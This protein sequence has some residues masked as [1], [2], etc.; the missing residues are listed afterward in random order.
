[1]NSKWRQRRFANSGTKN[2]WFKVPVASRGKQTSKRKSVETKS[3]ETKSVK[4]KCVKKKSSNKK[5][6][7]EC[8]PGSLLKAFRYMGLQRNTTKFTTVLKRNLRFR[9]VV[10]CVTGFTKKPLTAKTF[11][12][13]TDTEPNILYLIQITSTFTGDVESKRS[14]D[15]SHSISVFNNLIFDHN[16]QNP[17]PLTKVNVNKCCVGGRS[18]VFKHCSRV[19]EFTPTKQT[20]RFLSK[21]CSKN[22]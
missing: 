8:A 12:P 7:N 15:N 4:K 5:S 21:T 18:Y 3:V 19:V 20:K 2:L 6:L 22:E 14:K 9:S 16:I 11:N 17:L 13:V 10:D 1:M